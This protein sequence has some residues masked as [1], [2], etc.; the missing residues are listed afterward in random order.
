MAAGLLALFVLVSGCGTGDNGGGGGAG[1][2]DG[3][4]SPFT[5][6]KTEDGP[7]QVL[8]VKID[9]VDAARPQT[10]LDQADIV[11]AEQVEGG[12]SRLLAVFSSQLPDEVGPVRSGRES[13]LELLQQFG[14]PAF[15]YSGVQSRLLSLFEDAELFRVTPDTA[16]EAYERSDDRSAPYN[17][18]ADPEALLD[19]A[20]EASEAAD[21]GFRF[22]SAPASGGERTGEYD[23]SYPAA[24]F[25]FSWSEEDERWQVAMDGEESGLEAATV[26]VQQVTV[27]DSQYHDVNQN[28]SPYTE[29]TGSGTAVVLR[30]G[31]AY[32]AEWSRPDAD[33]GTEFTTPDGE[34]MQFARGPVWVVLQER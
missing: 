9:N 17:L 3:E 31:K 30:D 18:Y 19:A 6:L 27:R 11:Y 25:S 16:P 33:S 28:V 24:S 7:E 32:D 29:T 5:G 15:A 4:V 26:V 10:G 14:E 12:L 23:V 22:G 13:D 2:G 34:P 21:I 8:A 20:P 1:D